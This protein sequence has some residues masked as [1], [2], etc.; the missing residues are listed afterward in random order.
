MWISD[1]SIVNVGTDEEDCE[2]KKV[3]FGIA[4]LKDAVIIKVLKDEII[5]KLTKFQCGKIIHIHPDKDGFSFSTL[6]GGKA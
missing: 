1:Y 4:D 2:I 6:D 5:I 3:R